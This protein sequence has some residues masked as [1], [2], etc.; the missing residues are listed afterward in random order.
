MIKRIIP[1]LCIIMISICLSS[2]G[3]SKNK[4][5]IYCY[6]DYFDPEI[7]NEFEEKTGIKVVVDT[8]DTAEEMY[9]IIKNNV[10]SY[11]AIC[12]SDYML[13]RLYR[14]GLLQD[15][16][17]NNL[18]N[19]KN[20]NPK[21][22]KK[23][24]VYDKENKYSV[25]YAVGVLGIIYDQKKCGNE[26][27]NSWEALWDKK[28]KEKIVM[29]DSM[30]ENFIIALKKN[31]FSGNSQKQSE[32]KKATNDLIKQKPLVYKYANDSARDL[33]ADKSVPIGVVWNGEYKYIKDLNK[34]AEFIIPKEGSEF[35]IDSWVIP[36][37]AKN[38]KNAEKWID[39]LCD[40]NVAYK[41][42]KYLYYTTPNIEAEKEMPKSIKKNKNIVLEDSTIEN[43]EI[44]RVMPLKITEM[45]VKYWKEFKAS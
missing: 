36:T 41:N 28:L 23:A 10:A 33:V 16:D 34:N 24:Q 25:P 11:D 39:F 32:L 1:I 40:G 13:E 44:L 20:I 15:I 18:K 8:Y 38:K 3:N 4:I 42:F 17:F 31:G 19:I 37:K 6:G 30:R 45:Y 14:E 43:S 21:Y 26:I 22:M 29:P 7:I 9:P 12:G 35:F 5:H 27:P 2:C